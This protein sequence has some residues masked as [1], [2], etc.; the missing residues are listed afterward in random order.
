MRSGESERRQALT[1]DESLLADAEEQDR[2]V[3]DFL[4]AT[5]GRIAL[6]AVVLIAAVLTVGVAASATVS[7]RQRQ[8]ETLRSHT[9]PLADAAQRIY[10]ALSSANTTAA[11][12]FLAGGVEP[13]DVRD[14][15]DAAIGEASAGLVTA[16][17]GVSPNDIHSLKLLTDLSNQL[18][19]YT[20]M[21]ATARE[22]NRDGRP[23]G[24]AYLSE[25]SA[26]L[27]QSILPDAERLYRAQADVVTASGRSAV[28]PPAVVVGAALAVGL[29][30]FA[31]VFLARRSRRR[32]N[33]GLVLASVLM[34]VLTVWLTVAGLVV[35]HAVSGARTEGGEPLDSAVTARILV[36]QARADEI[37]GLLKRGSD[38]RFDIR[39]DE[40]TA[41]IGKLLD[42]HAVDGAKD[43][44]RGWMASH[45]AIRTKLG[46]GDYRGAVAIA[47]DEGPQHSTAQFTRLDQALGDEIARLRD[48]QRAG[49]THAYLALSTL[50]A[51][52]AAL[53]VLA[54]LAVAAGVAPRL[55]EY[56]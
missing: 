51:G 13:R 28:T 52:A 24:V 50:P 16:S 12:A 6:M 39:F 27:Q 53:G 21:M 1:L 54:A 32:L 5:P 23:I 35:V 40:R 43:A 46:D 4:R 26:L 20:G 37:L 11:T 17:N 25:S 34:T 44:L 56:H 9:E 3:V 48:R 38:N 22:S 33:A 15:Y 29:L 55:S 47:R 2:P 42:K 7:H 8:L 41:Q 31:Q 30:V 36:Q 19:V 10:S 14:R 45:D 49:I 18:A